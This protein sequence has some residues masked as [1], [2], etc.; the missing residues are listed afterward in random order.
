ME[1][2]SITIIAAIMLAIVIS[3]SYALGSQSFGKINFQDSVVTATE[4]ELA[5]SLPDPGIL[6]DHPLYFLKLTGER[7]K[8]FL[9]FNSEDKAALH[10]DFAKLRLSEAK[11]L[12]DQNKT[13]GK[14]IED[15]SMELN[16]TSASK[17]IKK[18]ANELAGR[19]AIVLAQ[20]LEK[21]PSRAKIAVERALNNS[22]EKRIEV[23]AELENKTR[24]EIREDIAKEAEVKN[25][26]RDAKRHVNVGDIRDIAETKGSS[27]P[28]AASTQLPASSA[29]P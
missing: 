19:S 1:N 17:R 13:L 3:P 7:V 22:I 10:L 4:L 25:S 24:G 16:Q 11:K 8:L 2:F 12:A 6:P 20:V 15:F 21:I 5:G 26:I 14:T 27:T 29:L 28:I 23:R 9:T 18:E